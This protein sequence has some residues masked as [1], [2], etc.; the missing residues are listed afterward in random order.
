[1]KM[2]LEDKFQRRHYTKDFYEDLSL[3]TM[4]NTISWNLNLPH[5]LASA[6]NL[7]EICI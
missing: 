3:K 2:I 1:M 5:L 7:S 4:V 6:N